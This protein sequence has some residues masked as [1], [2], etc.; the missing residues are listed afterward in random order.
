MLVFSERLNILLMRYS[1][2]FFFLL[3]IR[4]KI[5][6]ICWWDGG[7]SVTKVHTKEIGLEKT[8]MVQLNHYNTN[9]LCSLFRAVHF[10]SCCCL[11]GRAIVFQLPSKL[12][13]IAVQYIILFH[14]ALK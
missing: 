14:S 10:L 12:Q 3:I 11:L 5:Q 2:I 8:T 1:D 9:L 7:E 13:F 4:T 6:N